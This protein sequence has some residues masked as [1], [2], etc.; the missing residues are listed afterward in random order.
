[1]NPLF[2][3]LQSQNNNSN[4]NSNSYSNANNNVSINISKLR[5]EVL[6]REDRK[7]KTFEKVLDICYKKIITTNTTSDECCCTYICPQVIFGLPLFNLD[8]CI[9]FIMTKLVEKGFEVYLALPNNIFI[10]WQLESEKKG[11]QLTQ[12]YQLGTPRKQLKL[13]YN[14]SN[15]NLNKF[16]TQYINSIN[17]INNTNSNNTNSNNSNNSNNYNNSNNSNTNNKQY[18]PIEDYNQT[19]NIIYN[20]NDIDLFN[21]KINNLLI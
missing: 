20:N 19:D 3:N 21:N 13:E 14:N 16:S 2:Y 18:K 5:N 1:M 6:N 10:S 12:Y 11:Q 7:Y 4:T 17:S 9:K 8:E 15:N